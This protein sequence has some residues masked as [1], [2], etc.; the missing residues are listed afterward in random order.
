MAFA[1]FIVRLL[2]VTVGFA[3]L[4][5]YVWWRLCRD[6]TKPGSKWRPIGAVAL[7]ILAVFG[8]LARFFSPSEA[9]KIGRAH[10]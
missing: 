3:A 10:V 7:G 5:G 2:A 9:P 6:T 4:H 1:W 8:L